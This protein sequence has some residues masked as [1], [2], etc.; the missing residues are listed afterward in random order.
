[1]NQILKPIATTRSAARSAL[2]FKKT[3][4]EILSMA[5]PLTRRIETLKTR[6][7][8]SEAYV[9]RIKKTHKTLLEKLKDLEAKRSSAAQ[10]S[11]VE[12]SV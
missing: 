8:L 5:R 6:I 9:A 12:Q 7:A 11:P 4:K 10:S 2:S 1:M 3:L